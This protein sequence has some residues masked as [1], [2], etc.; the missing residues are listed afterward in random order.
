MYTRLLLVVVIVVVV[1]VVVI[2][3]IINCTWL[4]VTVL[5]GIEPTNA[6]C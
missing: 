4:E 1:V 6:N 3:Y 5:T 2:F